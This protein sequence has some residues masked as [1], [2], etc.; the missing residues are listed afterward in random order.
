V[1]TTRRTAAVLLAGLAAA[2]APAARAD[3]RPAVRVAPARPLNPAPLAGV[4][5]AAGEPLVTARGVPSVPPPFDPLGGPAAQPKP[6]AG[7]PLLKLVPGSDAPPFQPFPVPGATPPPAPAVTPV[8]ATT[9]APPPSRGLVGWVG[10]QAKAVRTFVVGAPA[11]PPP[12][13][14]GQ[15]PTGR[16]EAGRPPTPTAPPGGWNPYVPFPTAQQPAKPAAPP[17]AP[18]PTPFRGTTAGGQPT[19]A[20]NPAY[21]WYGWGTTTPGANP[22]APGGDYPKASA[23]WHAA[24]GATPGAFPVPVVNAF[25][26]PPGGDPPAYLVAESPAGRDE[27]G[28]SQA[29]PPPAPRP[30]AESRPTPSAPPRPF[31]PAWQPASVPITPAAVPAAP[32]SPPAADPTWQRPAGVPIVRGQRPDGPDLAELVRAACTGLATDVA[33][34]RDGT[35]V[36]VTFAAT[37]E[38]LA[39]LAARA[40]S[41][42][43]EL[44]PYHV[45]FTAR[46]TGR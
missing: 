23:G 4:G 43:P 28:R 38:G 33:V 40:V 31:D 34:T 25:R 22:F 2:V 19:Y 46:L 30:I 32:P 14:V 27:P 17:T 39:E 36:R 24:T 35:A 44:R 1:N 15:T 11:P 5:P 12:P 9:A 26:P 21:R 41:R 8:T 20:G 29:V 6:D 37:T 42:V 45:T 13:R 7:R 10:D 16:D 3:D 18:A